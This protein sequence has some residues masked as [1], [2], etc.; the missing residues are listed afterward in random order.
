[1]SDCIFGKPA[2][3]MSTQTKHLIVSVPIEDNTPIFKTLFD[4]SI[5]HNMK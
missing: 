3:K 2:S 5:N 1:M 4:F